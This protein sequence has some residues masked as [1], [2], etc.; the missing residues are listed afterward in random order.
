M[1]DLT[2]RHIWPILFTMKALALRHIHKIS[3]KNIWNMYTLYTFSGV[4]NKNR[5]ERND[6]A[7]SV[8]VSER[9]WKSKG[10]RRENPSSH[11]LLFTLER[12]M[13]GNEI[14]FS[15]YT[16]TT[17]QVYNIFINHI[18][19]LHATDTKLKIPIDTHAYVIGLCQRIVSCVRFFPCCCC[20][21]FL[22][23]TFIP[24]TQSL[25]R[26]YA[27]PAR[28]ISVTANMHTVNCKAS[29]AVGTSQC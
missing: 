21:C 10:R 4:C 24:L 27:L 9:E 18:K 5:T 28:C 6:Y 25:A 15:F 16:V 3:M 7:L 14:I 19:S 23:F 20:C 8:C 2:V 26:A 1:A 17:I 22:F 11:F 29:R 12:I 13:V